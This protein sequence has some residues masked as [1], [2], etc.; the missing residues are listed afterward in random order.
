[1]C[2]SPPHAQELLH[3]RLGPLAAVDAG[4]RTRDISWTDFATIINQSER[5][6]VLMLAYCLCLRGAFASRGHPLGL[7]KHQPH[8]PDSNNQLW[9]GN[10]AFHAFE[11]HTLAS[12]HISTQPHRSVGRISLGFSSIRQGDGFRVG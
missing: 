9:H 10:A 12:L 1:M 6:A 11:F 7:Y 4:E 2:T 3:R 5:Q 8:G